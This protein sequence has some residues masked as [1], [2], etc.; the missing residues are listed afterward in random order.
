MLCF[1]FVLP[2]LHNIMKKINRYTIKRS[3]KRKFTN[4]A[5]NLFG[6]L[7]KTFFT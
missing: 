1:V 2:F 4:F 5:V 3:L 7:P 6:K